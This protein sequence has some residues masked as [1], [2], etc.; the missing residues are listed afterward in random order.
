MFFNI[1]DRLFGLHLN[2]GILWSEKH[3]PV[4]NDQKLTVESGPRCLFFTG[5]ATSKLDWRRQ[6]N[7]LTPGQ[8]AI[9][10]A[11]LSVASWGILVGIVLALRALV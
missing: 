7:R 9:V 6:P 4:L 3:A 10:I 2:F 5:S 1:S 8:S 11:V